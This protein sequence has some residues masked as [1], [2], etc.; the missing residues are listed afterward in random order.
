M[1]VVCLFVSA[2]T[3]GCIVA[4]MHG[5]IVA[6]NNSFVTTDVYG[7]PEVKIT[8]LGPHA[9]GST[10]TLCSNQNYTIVF[11]CVIVGASSLLWMLEPLLRNSEPFVF[12]DDLGEVDKSSITLVL[13]ERKLESLSYK[14]QLHVSTESLR[15][16]IHS[17]GSSL[18]V[19]CIASDDVEESISI[20]VPGKY[21]C[22]LLHGWHTSPIDRW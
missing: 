6:S 17:R 19:T 8:L 7:I 5:L 1:Q 22:Y 21:L 10:I 2:D 16:A 11:E 15:G 20:K 14:S 12:S 9:D 4:G 3:S 13:I 18:N